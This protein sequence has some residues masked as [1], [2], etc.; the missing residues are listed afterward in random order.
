MGAH[1]ADFAPHLQSL[2]GN[3]RATGIVE[4]GVGIAFQHRLELTH[5]CISFRTRNS[6][7]DLQQAVDALLLKGAIERVT[8]VTSLGYYSGLFLVPAACDRSLH[9][10]P[11]HGSSTLQDGDA[12]VRPFSHKKSG[13]D[14][15]DRHP[16][17]L[18]SCSDAPGCPQV[19][20]L[21]GQQASLPVHL[22]PFRV[23]DITSGVHQAAAA[24][25]SAV[26]AAKST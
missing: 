16:R 6:R 5:Q 22:P 23:S 13:V 18:P 12:R 24:C 4:E 7:Q 14:S 25:H 21:R 9:S 10:Q 26:K 15:I 3:C 8:N 17:C 20:T 19:S 2:L 11:P 1:L